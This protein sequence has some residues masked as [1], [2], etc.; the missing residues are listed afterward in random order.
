MNTAIL[1]NGRGVRHTS[2]T[3]A[4]GKNVARERPVPAGQSPSAV[5]SATGWSGSVVRGRRMGKLLFV[6]TEA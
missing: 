6:A 4:S 5:V 1:S 2:D 3:V